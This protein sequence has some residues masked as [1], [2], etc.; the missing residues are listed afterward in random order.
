MQPAVVVASLAAL[1]ASDGT[2]LDCVC[3][4]LRNITVSGSIWGA[5]AGERYIWLHYCEYPEWFPVA[6]ACGPPEHHPSA[7]DSPV[8]RL[9]ARIWDYGL[10]PPPPAGGWRQG[11]G[12]RCAGALAELRRL[13]WEEAWQL[14]E[15]LDCRIAGDC[16]DSCSVP[17]LNNME[18]DMTTLQMDDLRPMLSQ[19][20]QA[21]RRITRATVGRMRCESWR[22][23]DSEWMYKTVFQERLSSYWRDM[24]QLLSLSAT[25]YSQLLVPLAFEDMIIPLVVLHYSP[26]E[27]YGR[28]CCGADKD[29]IYDFDPTI[30]RPLLSER[31]L[32]YQPWN[33]SFPDDFSALCEERQPELSQVFNLAASLYAAYRVYWYAA[34]EYID[35]LYEDEFKTVDEEWQLEDRSSATLSVD[36]DCV[37]LLA[38][39]LDHP[40][41]PLEDLPLEAVK[42]RE[43][44]RV[45]LWDDVVQRSPLIPVTSYLAYTQ[46][47]NVNLCLLAWMAVN[48]YSICQGVPFSII[49][50]VSDARCYFDRP[51]DQSCQQSNATDAICSVSRA[52]LLLRWKPDHSATQPAELWRCVERRQ[53]W[54]R[55]AVP[56]CANYGGQSSESPEPDDVALYVETFV[57]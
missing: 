1:L 49:Q 23:P 37:Q 53:R 44:C 25:H 12:G 13:A 14:V 11:G 36:T 6:V 4:H 40:T 33:L 28:A 45:Q 21:V 10:P 48:S 19:S 57:E 27:R 26:A 43:Q 50:S 15:E 46:R 41:C 20:L 47:V 31:L 16:I 22:L 51:D 39:A 29:A 56:R 42:Q 54:G 7:A 52:I 8:E 38:N 34:A 24:A 18:W 32:R 35:L 55:G 30:R 9:S 2:V 5:S 17:R 3:T